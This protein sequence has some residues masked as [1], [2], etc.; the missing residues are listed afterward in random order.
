MGRALDRAWEYPRTCVPR[1]DG[2]HAALGDVSSVA[3]VYRRCTEA[4]EKELG[5]E[6]SDQTR[7]LFERLTRGEIRGYELRQPVSTGEFGSLY[8][9][10]HRLVDREVAIKVLLPEY[11]NQPDFIRR[12]EAEAQLIAR[13]EHPHIL[14]LY[15]YW[16]EPDGA[17]IVMRWMRGGSLR[18]LLRKGPLSTSAATRLVDQI[19]VAALTAAHRQGLVHGHLKPEN[20]L[21]DD[22]GNG[23]LTHFGIASDMRRLR[24]DG[25][26]AASK[27]LAYLAPEQ[28]RGEPATPLSDQYSLGLVVAEVLTGRFPRDKLK[29]MAA[30]IN[31]NA[32]TPRERRPDL[33]SELDA[34]IQRATAQDPAERYSDVTAFVTALHQALGTAA[35]T[36]VGKSDRSRV[37]IPNPYKGLRAFQQ[38]DAPDF[39]GREALTEGLLTRLEN[40]SRL[41]VFSPS[42]DQAV[43]VNLRWL[44]PACSR[45][46]GGVRCLARKSGSSWKCRLAHIRWKSW[47]SVCCA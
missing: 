10:Y 24:G 36:M 29:A 39:F 44:R 3:A 11:A 34:V 5:V 46:Y 33:P 37:E 12:F 42:L 4:L 9:A 43:A 6:P 18:V 40:P 17:Y 35:P 41:G 23:Y 7:A 26:P 28:I 32:A 1:P 13:V 2:A 25:Q 45:R 14:P 21:F 38:A 16:R 27:P 20:I 30:G 22:E 15:D 19:A 31:S 8:R 47:R